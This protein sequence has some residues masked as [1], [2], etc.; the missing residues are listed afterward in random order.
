MKF[1]KKPVVVAFVCALLSLAC[2]D[3]ERPYGYADWVYELTDGEWHKQSTV[4]NGTGDYCVTEWAKFRVAP[5]PTGIHKIVTMRLPCGKKP[6]EET[7][8]PVE[9][10]E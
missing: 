9:E 10:G 1:R 2:S 6:M 8:E 7:Y 4:R 5:P 3:D